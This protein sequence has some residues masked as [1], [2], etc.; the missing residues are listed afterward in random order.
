MTEM[1]ERGKVLRTVRRL[2]QLGVHAT[3]TTVLTVLRLESGR[4]WPSY[5]AVQMHLTGAREDGELEQA[6]RGR[7]YYLPGRSGQ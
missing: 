6:R 7:P 1:L 2:G 3:P 4:L 5:D